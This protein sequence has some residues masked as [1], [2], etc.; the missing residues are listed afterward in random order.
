MFDRDGL[1]DLYDFTT[2]TWESLRRAVER[3]PESAFT[4]PVDGSGWP[5]LRDAV[6]HLAGG[7]D[8]WLRDR[9]APDAVLLENAADVAT[10]SA[11]QAYR[12]V[13]R[14]WLRTAIESTPDDALVAQSEAMLPGTPQEFRVSPAD[15]IAHI[16]LHERGHFGDV[17]TLIH[18]HGGSAPNAD[19]LTYIFFARRERT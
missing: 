9:V 4:Q 16:L 12:N 6:F 15:V 2:F 18:A 10:I 5:S 19:Y 1:R 14:G 11:T 7:W 17:A 8:R 3:L 13:V